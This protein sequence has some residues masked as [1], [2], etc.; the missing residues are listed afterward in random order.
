MLFDKLV[1]NGKSY[2]RAIDMIM[3]KTNDALEHYMALYEV[4]SAKE[5]YMAYMSEGFV[6]NKKEED[7]LL[8]NTE[9]TPG[10]TGRM[11][12]ILQDAW[13][14]IVRWIKATILKIKSVFIK[15][16]VA[17]KVSIL[18]K[19]AAKNPLIRNKKI[20][21]T[22]PNPTFLEK[23]KNDVEMIRIKLKT[24]KSFEEIRRD[25]EN[26]EREEKKLD[27]MKKAKK[28]AVIVVTVAVAIVLLKQY[29][30]FRVIEGKVAEPSAHI[31]AS[32][33]ESFRE[34]TTAKIN[35]EKVRQ[36]VVYAQH[37]NIFVFLKETPGKLFR[38][39]NGMKNVNT[40]NMAEDLFGDDVTFNPAKLNRDA[41]LKK[42]GNIKQTV[43]DYMASHGNTQWSTNDDDLDD[44]ISEDIGDVDIHESVDAYIENYLYS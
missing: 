36:K 38:A 26:L 44:D 17:K 13:E 42:A 14:N 32:Q 25:M 43:D 31:G 2:D 28:A 19:M 7:Y 8:N 18:E 23:L 40:G 37:F 27:M 6:L 41:A 22:D 39:I 11:V 34:N 10:I 12:R 4:E 30:D 29:M 1:K 20:E 15:R 33:Q 3:E 24:G 9:A 21:I 5:D 35:V 16:E